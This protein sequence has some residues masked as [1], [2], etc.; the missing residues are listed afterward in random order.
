MAV[1]VLAVSYCL[2]YFLAM[3]LVKPAILS[4]KTWHSATHLSSGSSNEIA[5]SVPD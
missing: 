3:A 4:P 2:Y 1:I 5:P